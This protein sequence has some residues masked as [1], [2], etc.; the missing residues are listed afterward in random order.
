MSYPTLSARIV[1]EG[2]VFRVRVDEIAL[3]SGRQMRVD[4]VEHPDSVSIVPLDEEMNACFVR[5]Y[6]H[7]SGGKL[8]ELPAG[9][10]DP[11]ETPAACAAR[12]CR[13]ETGM[14]PSELAPLG[15]FYLVPGY[16]TEFMHVFLATGLTRSPLPADSDE[17]ISTEWIPLRQAADMALGGGIK[18]AKTIA[19][20]ALALHHLSLLTIEGK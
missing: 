9:T 18:D 13:E 1:F 19:S 3:A 2:K 6:R 4:V 7:P 12:E 20:I 10:L 11:G 17:E 8:L 5:Q 14:A 16:G 15:G